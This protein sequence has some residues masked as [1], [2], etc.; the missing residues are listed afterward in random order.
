MAECVCLNIV[1]MKLANER[2]T[3]ERKRVKVVLHTSESSVYNVY[4]CEACVRKTSTYIGTVQIDKRA[5]IHYIYYH[6]HHYHN[7]TDC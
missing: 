3:R 2:K 6:R 4:Q 5:F 1:T 7:G